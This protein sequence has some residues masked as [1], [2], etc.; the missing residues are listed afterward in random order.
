MLHHYFLWYTNIYGKFHVKTTQTTLLNTVFWQCW[1]CNSPAGL[2]SVVPYD[3][4]HPSVEGGW[5]ANFQSLPNTK[6]I[7]I[8]IEIPY[9]IS[10][11]CPWQ[12][13]YAGWKGVSSFDNFDVIREIMNPG[14]AI[15]L[16]LLLKHSWVL[17]CCHSTLH[18][19]SQHVF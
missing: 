10:L 2:Y 5:M 1:C 6:K 17:W 16:I 19:K 18:M 11:M 8:T 13:F 7:H 3:I 9:R 14:Y 12:G 15:S 4:F